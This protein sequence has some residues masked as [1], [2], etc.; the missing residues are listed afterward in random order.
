MSRN[1]KREK[2]RELTPREKAF[3]VEYIKNHASAAKAYALA[4]YSKNGAG[5]HAAR[6]KARPEVQ[7][8]IAELAAAEDKQAV[9]DAD[10]V[11]RYLTAVM[12]GTHES[13][14]LVTV[15]IGKGKTEA[16]SVSKRPEERDQ[17]EAAKILAKIFGILTNKVDLNGGLQVVQIIDDVPEGGDL[18]GEDPSAYEDG[19]SND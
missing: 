16:R 7:E 3:C 10:E 2:R 4:G 9:A 1:R 8:Y 14:V 15:G 12:R 17:L 18:T 13:S 6:L 11:M 5:A 19:E